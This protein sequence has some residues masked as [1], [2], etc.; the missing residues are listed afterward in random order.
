MNWYDKPK[1]NQPDKYPN[2][3]YSESE[4]QSYGFLNPYKVQS[5]RTRGDLQIKGKITVVDNDNNT[6]LVMGFL[7][8]GF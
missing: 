5:G 7:E 4:N 3:D 8:N 1:L 6:R 2:M